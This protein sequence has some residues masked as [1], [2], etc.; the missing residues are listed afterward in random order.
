MS[1]T[2]TYVT[3]AISRA[4]FDEIHV[5]LEAADYSHAFERERPKDDTG[6]NPK[7][8]EVVLIDMHGLALV[9]EDREGK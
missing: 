7:V 8:A 1:Y 2:H 6:E 5:K 4:A 3:L 9:P